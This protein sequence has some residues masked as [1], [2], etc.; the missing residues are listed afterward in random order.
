VGD[1][2]RLG[3]SLLAGETT[4]D[5]IRDLTKPFKDAKHYINDEMTGYATDSVVVEGDLTLDELDTFAHNICCLVVTGS[6]HVTGVYGD[7]D[8]PETA[9][10]VLGDFHAKNA[11]TNGALFVAGDVTVDEVLLGTGNDHSAHI[12]GDVAATIFTSQYHHFDI[13][14]ALRVRH[15]VGDDTKYRVSDNHKKLAIAPPAMLLELFEPE[16]LSIDTDEPDNT[17]LNHRDL[18]AKLAKSERVLRPG[19][20][21]GAPTTKTNINATTKPKATAKPKT[22]AKAKPKAKTNPKTKT[23]PKAKA[24]AKPSKKR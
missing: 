24:K 7:Y 6:L 1:K 8:Y 3:R 14:G 11:I 21:T 12:K 4:V 5:E 9:V 10:F 19:V 13:G 22:K 15:I 17:E 20:V 16:L 18:T 23:K 2:P